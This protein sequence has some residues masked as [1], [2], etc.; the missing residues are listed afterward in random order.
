[1]PGKAEG[2]FSV[3]TVNTDDVGAGHEEFSREFLQSV[4][5]PGLLLSFLKLNIGM[6]IM[7]LRNLWPSEGLCNGTRLVV[8]RLI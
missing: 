8:T 1:M 4:N 2:Y 6:S 5:L 3:N 7:L